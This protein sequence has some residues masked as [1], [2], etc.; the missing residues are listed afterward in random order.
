MFYFVFFQNEKSEKKEI[1]LNSK[2]NVVCVS[3]FLF[4]GRVPTSDPHLKITA[5]CQ[6]KSCWVIFN[7]DLMYS[8]QQMF[9]L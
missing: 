8:G 9:K 4:P 5:A 6:D 7:S 1:K 2:Y 3:G